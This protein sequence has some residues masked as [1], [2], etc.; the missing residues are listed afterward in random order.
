MDTSHLK[1]DRYHFGA[2]VRPAFL[3]VL[4]PAV[5]IFL[6]AGG[7]EDWM[8]VVLSLLLVGGVPY[9]LAEAAADA[10]RRKQA[11]L[12]RSWGGPPVT[13]LLRY[14]QT[15][16]N[17]YTFRRVRERIGVLCPD[18]PL[19]SEDD[20]RRDR[21]AASARYNACAD[22]LRVMFRDHPMVLKAN[23]AY[24]FRRNT[25]AIRGW[26]FAGAGASLL[27]VGVHAW[28]QGP[29]ELG[30]AAGAVS[31][32]ALIGFLAATKRWV[33]EPGFIYARRLL[34]AVEERPEVAREG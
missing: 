21:M 14:E 16:L 30:I 8:R 26:G 5:A 6:W 27:A 34:E 11:A 7:V 28:R 4:A 13:Q 25:W 17:P 1:A 9:V 32:G 33:R 24:G 23:T 10:G 29:T 18:V 20:E 2:R 3:V 12:W 15:D 31:V 22:R 19:P